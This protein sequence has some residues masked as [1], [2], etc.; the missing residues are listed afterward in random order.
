MDEHKYINV[1]GMGYIMWP[2]GVGELWH[3]QVGALF[4][5]KDILSA[6]MFTINDGKVICFGHSESLGIRSRA[7]DSADLAAQLGL[8]AA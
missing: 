6:G 4:N 7:T 2:T 5:R 3:A 1:A 8:K